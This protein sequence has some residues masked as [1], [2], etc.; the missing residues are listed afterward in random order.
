MS[1]FSLK[2]IFFLLQM[3]GMIKGF[4]GGGPKPLDRD[5][6]FGESAGKASSSVAKNIAGAG[7]T[8]LQVSIF[9]AI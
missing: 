5:E 7:M 1:V 3:L 6:L 9:F 8:S 2:I 4:F